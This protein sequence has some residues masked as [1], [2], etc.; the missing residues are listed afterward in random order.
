MSYQKPQTAYEIMADN[1]R[2][3]GYTYD[4]AKPVAS[5]DTKSIEFWVK[6]GV[7]YCLVRKEQD[8]IEFFKES[9]FPS[10]T[11]NV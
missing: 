2:R 11:A 6:D 10:V 7:R 9:D 5:R 1:L 4:S 8:G 3:T